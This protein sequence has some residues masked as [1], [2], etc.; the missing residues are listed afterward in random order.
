MRMYMNFIM[1]LS[2]TMAIAYGSKLG[3]LEHNIEI[4]AEDWKDINNASPSLVAKSS[5]R[6]PR[7]NNFDTE[8]SWNKNVAASNSDELLLE[9]KAL[10]EDIDLLD[11]MATVLDLIT[12]LSAGSGVSPEDSAAACEGR[13]YAQ[14]ENGE[15][16]GGTACSKS[17]FCC[18]TDD[19]VLEYNACGNF[20]GTVCHGNETNPNC[21]D[22]GACFGANIGLVKDGSCVGSFT[23]FNSSLGS[24]EE[25]SCIGQH[26]CNLRGFTDSNDIVIKGQSCVGRDAC[27]FAD[28]LSDGGGI[29]DQSCVGYQSC[30]RARVHEHIKNQSCVGSSAC[31]TLSANH[32]N[33]GSCVG[34][35]SCLHANVTGNITSNSCIGRGICWNVIADDDLVHYLSTTSSPTTSSPTTSSS[36]TYN[37]A[38]I[39]LVLTAGGSVFL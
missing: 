13:G 14:Y 36:A 6:Q 15:L 16:K 17:T 11:E 4:L 20:T 18:Y 33:D 25:G 19:S 35:G 24:I 1:F 5:G 29:Q 32:V 3:I 23:C 21:K 22:E 34:E 38:K 9:N 39:F 26:A 37:I 31:K 2:M 27:L 8:L 7:H 12:P 10:L 28:I 30:Y